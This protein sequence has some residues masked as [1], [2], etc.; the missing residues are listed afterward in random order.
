MNE[1]SKQLLDSSPASE[2][3]TTA[4]FDRILRGRY[5]PDPAIQGEDEDDPSWYLT[6]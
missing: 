2:S 6:D 1:L 4:E 5:I 3:T